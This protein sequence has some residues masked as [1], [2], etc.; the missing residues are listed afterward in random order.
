MMEENVTDIMKGIALGLQSLGLDISEK[1]GDKVDY[2]K[3]IDFKIT[4]AKT[5]ENIHALF[6][7]MFY[8]KPTK[9]NFVDALGFRAN[10]AHR[11]TTEQRP[12]PTASDEGF[13][14]YDSTLKKKI[15]WN[16]T[17]WV[18]IDGTAL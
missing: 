13:E 1:E 12:T 7:S 14:Y 4:N 5:G 9:P 11:G 16:G 8:Y 6:I 18:N 10:L 2:V 3:D 15:L 17:K